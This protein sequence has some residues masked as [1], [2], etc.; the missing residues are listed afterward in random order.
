MVLQVTKLGH[1]VYEAS[2]VHCIQGIVRCY[3]KKQALNFY[4]A[5]EIAYVFDSDL[6]QSVLLYIIETHCVK[7]E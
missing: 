3:K 1:R 2:F 7:D 5:L 4:S 6:W